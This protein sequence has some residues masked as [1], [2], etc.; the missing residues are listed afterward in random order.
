[1]VGRGTHESLLADCP[2]YGEIVDSQRSAEEVL[3]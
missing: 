3:A 1:V 2:T